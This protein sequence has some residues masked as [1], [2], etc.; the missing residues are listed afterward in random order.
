MY[1][2]T[3]LYLY[4]YINHI[5]SLRLPFLYHLEP[6]CVRLAT[7]IATCLFSLRSI[8]PLP[9][10]PNTIEHLYSEDEWAQEESGKGRA[11]SSTEIMLQSPKVLQVHGGVQT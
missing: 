5:S 11:S 6:V 7:S 9:N 4:L 3:P 8:P 2:K 10:S 1:Y